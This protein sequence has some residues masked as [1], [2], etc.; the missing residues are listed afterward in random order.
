MTGRG[1]DRISWETWYSR[2]IILREIGRTGQEKLSQSRIA[3]AGVGGLGTWSAE[4]CARMGFG[5]IRVIDRDIVEPTNLHRTSLFDRS[6]V[7]MPKAE[8]VAE[9]LSRLNPH[10]RIEASTANIDETT[11]ED[12]FDDV[13]LIIDGLDN[14]RARKVL[15][16]ASRLHEIPLIFGGALGM[17]GN[18]TSFTGKPTDPCLSCLY[19][20]IDDSSLPTCETV[21][22]HPAILSIIASIQVAEASKFAITHQGNLV[23]RLLFVDLTRM[24]FDSVEY[25]QSS[26]CLICNQRASKELEAERHDT[27]SEL[28]AFRREGHGLLGKVTELCGTNNFAVRPNKRIYIDVPKSMEKLRLVY[29]NIRRLGKLGLKIHLN[30]EDVDIFLFHRGNATIRGPITLKQAS[31]LYDALMQHVTYREA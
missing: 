8:V 7:D 24:S 6:H 30:E 1:N 11:R 10:V 4:L 31:K 20:T 19:G 18:V 14:F 9:V 21:G 27:G 16:E 29:P 22:V 13:D 15:N 25:K 12:L 26:H 2:Q 23:R 3:I 5:F 17:S 28:E